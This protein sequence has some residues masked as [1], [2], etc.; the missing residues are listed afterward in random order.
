[1]PPQ[2]HPHHLFFFFPFF[3]KSFSTP[4]FPS[5]VSLIHPLVSYLDQ[6]SPTHPFPRSA[7]THP[8]SLLSPNTPTDSASDEADITD[9]LDD[10]DDCLISS[11][12]TEAEI[13]NQIHRLH[14]ELEE[15]RGDLDED[16]GPDIPPTGGSSAGSRSYTKLDGM[17]HSTS[18]GPGA[19]RPP[20]LIV[21]SNRLPVTLSRD[22][23]GKWDFRV[24]SG[25]LVSALAG[26]KNK[27]PFVWVGW[28]GLEVAATEQEEMKTRFQEE[29]NCYPV[30]LSDADANLYY[31]GFCNEVL[32]PLFHYVPLPIVSGDGER[33]FDFKYWDAYSKANHRFAEAVMQVYE[34]GDLVWVQDYHLM[35]LPSLLR[36]RLRDVTIGFFLHTP[37]PSSE[38]Y[39]ILPVRNKVLQGVLAADLIGF[40]T[41]DY[42]RHFLSVCTRILGLEASPRGVTYKDH[43]ANVGIFP[44]GIDP[45]YWISALQSPAVKERILDLE[46]RFRD[47]KVLLGVDRL[48]YIKG[49]PHK[50]MAFEILLARQPELK[51]K[52]VLVQI[53]VPSRTE[54]DE[55]KKLI[56]Q[57]N[58][59]VGR[60]NAQ[61]GSVEYAPI[62]FINQSVTFLDLCALY[63][64]ADV[65]VVTSVRDGMNLV[66][67]EYVV[68]QQQRHGVLVLSEFAGSAQS[69]SSAIR[70]N[71]WNIE[72]L[73]Q[74]MYE[75][76]TLSE[77]ERALK[78][79][80]LY[81]YVTKHTAAFWA[82]SFVSELQQIERLMKAQDVPKARQSLL[83]VSVDIVPELRV[84]T[85]RLFLFEYEGTLCS[86]VS[87]QD[88]ARPPA[89]LRRFL[90][91][92]STDTKNFVYIM[93][94]RSMETLDEWFG[95]LDVGLISE[96]GCDYRHATSEK[97]VPLLPNTSTS[98]RDSVTPILQYFTERTPGA[99]LEVKDRIVTWHF[100]DADPM[101]GSWQAKEL[102]LLLAENCMSLPVEV[103]SGHKYLEIRPVG[104]SLVG[105]VKRVVSE[106]SDGMDFAFAIG[107]DKATEEVYSFLNT[108]LRSG[109]GQ[110]GI[111]TC[112]VGGKSDNSAA[113]RYV[114]DSD[115]A[116]RV[117]R[118][119]VQGSTG[120][121]KKTRAGG[122]VGGPARGM[123]GIGRNKEMMRRLTQAHRSSSFDAGLMQVAR[124]GGRQVRVGKLGNPALEARIASGGGHG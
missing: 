87:L 99:H 94:G 23:N 45:N 38:V 98:W 121:L 52:V 72:E 53:G 27:I 123:G 42:A 97:W 9:E 71:P 5:T 4:L 17:Q 49:V 26:V 30:F 41:Y 114:P 35:L 1:M 90:Q 29:L 32:W 84:R 69:L 80:K 89:S 65:A 15:V 112:R 55:Y 14:I 3:F 39:R 20:K 74:A 68:C 6:M 86:P 8:A 36:E 102:Q 109:D 58:E 25:G 63:T 96:H 59:L 124:R 43:F 48:D 50:L 47:K 83:R 120:G 108:V 93:S 75:A 7:P 85:H 18:V 11:R 13:L 79:W 76:L 21:V 100:M 92:L 105:A 22:E 57:T 104:A 66:S 119:L 113:D 95:D 33:K 34:H 81:H 24:S 56:S 78:H 115:V 103:I 64:V 51:G 61:Y 46:E 101:F 91:R 31:N 122:V 88:L 62:V 77:R 40:H 60:I 2:T 116:V 44:I 111:M 73:S 106:L 82:S 67:Y 28:T 110:V 118:E 117:L 10:S 37:F 54:V 16:E 19:G 107:S 70:V 12:P